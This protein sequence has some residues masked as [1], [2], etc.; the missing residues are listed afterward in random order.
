MVCS[1]PGK[2]GT[3]S[4]IYVYKRPGVDMFLRRLS[5]LFEITIFT[6]SIQKYADAIMDKLDYSGYC[7]H[8]LYREHCSQ[9]PHGGTNNIFVKDLS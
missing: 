5:K 4:N 2:E 6:A 8:R 3:T 1:V 9:I 7:K